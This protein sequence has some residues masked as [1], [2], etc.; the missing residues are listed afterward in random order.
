VHRS[1]P[2]S[3][4]RNRFVEVSRE[5]H[6]LYAKLAE[7]EVERAAGDRGI[8]HDEMMRRLRARVRPAAREAGRAL[9][10]SPCAA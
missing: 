5:R 7:A 3:D 4:L 10:S 2:I 9:T 8:T 6:R 1:R